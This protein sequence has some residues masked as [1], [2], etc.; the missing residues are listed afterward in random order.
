MGAF[1]IV[2]GLYLII[3]GKS[4]DSSL[5]TSKI[6]EVVTS[7]QDTPNDKDEDNAKTSKEDHK[8]EANV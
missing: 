6:I 4:K 3:W 7:D 1:V 2:V 5:S 8:G